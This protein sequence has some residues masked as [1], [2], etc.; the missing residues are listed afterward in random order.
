MAKKNESLIGDHGVT[1]KH[2]VVGN[3][4]IGVSIVLI[5]LLIVCGI[6]ALVCA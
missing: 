5:I 2:D 6:F 1:T 4:V 3:S